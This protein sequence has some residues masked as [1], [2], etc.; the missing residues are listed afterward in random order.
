MLLSIYSPQDHVFSSF[1]QL[2]EEKDDEKL[3]QHTVEDQVIDG[4]TPNLSFR[5]LAYS[6]DLNF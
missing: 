4:L 2:R 3:G 6:D 5:D 1:F